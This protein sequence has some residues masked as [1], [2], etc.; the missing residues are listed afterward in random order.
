MGAPG[1]K[2]HAGL[3]SLPA[4]ALTV[5]QRSLTAMQIQVAGLLQFAAPRFPTT[6]VRRPAPPLGHQLGK[7]RESPPCGFKGLPSKRN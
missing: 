2:P 7:E 6:E 4:Q 5:F 1:S 3:R